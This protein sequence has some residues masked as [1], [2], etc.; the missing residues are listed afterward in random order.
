MI[1]LD[2]AATTMPKPAGVAQAV[3]AAINSYGNP[4]RGAYDASLNG[5]RCLFKTRAAISELF[6][7]GDPM[8]VALT[9]NATAALNIAIAKLNCHIVTTAAEHNSVLR[10]VYR[11]G[12][13]SVV[14]LDSL[15]RLDMNRLE[16]AIEPKTGAVVMTHASNLTGNVFDI[17]TAGKICRRKGV[18]LIVDAAQTAG[19]L[20]IAVQ[21]IGISALCF[22]GH[23]S[24]YGP[25]GTGGICLGADF[26]PDPLVVGGS[27]VES[28]AMNHPHSLPDALE[29]GT[30]NSHSFA[31]LLAGITY[32]SQCD[33]SV[34]S[35]ADRHAR[36]FAK[37][38]G[39]GERV[40]M[41]GDLQAP[42]RTPVVALNIRGMD[43]AEVATLLVEQYDIAVRA[44]AH[45]APLMHETLGTVRT[46]AVRFSFSHFN[47]DQ[48]VDRA[49]GA[50]KEIS[51]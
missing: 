14:P 37:E 3:A 2:N 28:F 24:L 47:T 38:V 4:S 39:N 27:G 22:S 46:G 15:G 30:Q 8:R 50:V 33:G 45:C 26:Q 48:E 25:Q 17:R 29:A 40:V 43:S 51:K 19:L 10:P 18:R 31:G 7:V 11:G 20:P 49:I 21:D 34:F 41:Y 32:V 1:Y 36:R 9:Q 13:Y 42:V 23:K 35:E 12:N 6:G 16:D 5:L 44:G